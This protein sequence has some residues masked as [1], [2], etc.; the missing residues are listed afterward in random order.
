MPRKIIGLLLLVLLLC[1]LSACQSA[2]EKEPEAP[3]PDLPEASER[4]PILEEVEV[5]TATVYYATTDH[6]YLLPLNISINATKEVAKV[7]M[8][9]LLAGPPNTFAAAVLPADVK[10]LDLYS[11]DTT[12]YVNLTADVLDIPAEQAQLAVD[13]VLCSILPL[14]EGFKLQLLI[15]GKVEQ[16]LGGVDIGAPLAL[17]QINLR[18]QE[19]ELLAAEEPLTGTPLTYYVSD[20]QSMYLVP[21]TMFYKRE[22]ADEQPA[23]EA[24]ARAVL[25]ELLRE[26]PEESHLYCPFWPGTELLDLYV[27]DSVAYV[28][29]SEELTGYGG[30]SAF[31]IMLVSC[32]VHSLTG[33]PGISGVQILVEGTVWPSLPE[34]TE[35]DKPLIPTQ[36]LNQVS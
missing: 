23:A 14:V 33:L 36:V 11:S 16:N 21:L 34:G 13:A 3:L 20:D 24:Y 6:Q 1:S 12:V 19:R 29:F 2:C 25:A 18:A 31:E 26:Q 4:L 9:K 27:E 17:P 22:A 30:G 7:A 15:E 32:L 5:T 28:D 8:E 10:L 35:I